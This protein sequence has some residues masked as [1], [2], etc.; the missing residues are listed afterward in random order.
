M[1]DILVQISKAPGEGMVASFEGQIECTSARHVVDLPVVSTS[2]DRTEGTSGHGAYELTHSIDNATPHLREALARGT[3]FGTAVISIMQ[4]L[5]GEYQAGQT[6]TLENA[7]VTEMRVETPLD[8]ETGLPSEEPQ[9]M[10]ALTYSG[11]T[12]AIKT[13]KQEGDTT[14]ID[15]VSGTYSLVSMTAE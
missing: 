4:N 12:W 9:E 15:T 6:I 3:N 11:I 10:F 8:P 1:S 7:Y 5:A 2:A 14:T 13:A